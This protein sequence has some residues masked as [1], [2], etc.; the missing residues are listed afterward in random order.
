MPLD[1]AKTFFLDFEARSEVDISK[2]G[3]RAYAEHPS[4]ELLCCAFACGNEPVELWLPGEPFPVPHDCSIWAA[5]NKDTERFLLQYKLGV[6]IPPRSWVDL[7]TVA[8]AAGL[9]RNLH[10]IAEALHLPVKKQAKTA[11]LA[12]A[13]PRKLSKKNSE[14]WWS[15]KERPELYQQLYDYCR[16]DV[17]VLRAS[18]RAIP[19][20]LVMPPKEERLAVLTD[21]MNDRGV[22]V[23]LEAVALASAVVETHGR[24]LRERFQQLYPDVNPRHPPSVAKA[25]GLANARKETVRDE[26]K[27][28][29]LDDNAREALTVLKTI[30][31]ASTAKLKAFKNHACADGKVHGAMV[32]HGAGRT[33]R[34]S[35]MGVQLHNLF[36]GLHVATPDWPAIDTSD[37]AMDKFFLNLRSGL[38]DLIYPDPTRAV[39]AAMRGFIYDD[40]VGLLSG[41]FAQI[42]A[43]VLVSWARQENA[44]EAFRNKRDLYKIQAASIYNVPVE[45]VNVDQRFM[46]KTA[47]LSAG[48]QVGKF[49]FRA[50]LKE[51]FDIEIDLEES[52]R[53]VQGYRRANPK[54]KQLWYDV[55]A[56]AK[57]VLLERAERWICSTSV[58]LI[59]MRL[60]TLGPRTWLLMRLP[61]GRCLWYYE[62]ELMQGENGLRIVYWGRDIKRGGMW[63]RV[64]TYGGKLVENGTQAMAREVLAD[65]MLRLDLAGFPLTMQ[66]HDSVTAPAP[67]ERL[68]EFESLMRLEPK[69]FP[70]LPIDVDVYHG[71]RYEG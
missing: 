9:P 42:E 67:A 59:A 64:D 1:L 18:L 65:A 21:A 45:N 30:K 71:T 50:N 58:P 15:K 69:W 38:F 24:E 16:T 55:D 34:W 19:Y 12:L 56:L 48:Y 3:A 10:D 13:K 25:F 32:F 53:I 44:V 52:D 17:E 26:L 7:A 47:V 31:T 22:K 37:D 35:S 6:I 11:L 68:D 43:R 39:A 49:G 61:T 5:Q 23:D 20:E 60:L 4:T 51:K 70:G 41:D 40:E 29:D 8:S 2:V 14:K 36:R 62:P 54:V 27:F 33:G 28:L 66:V 46:G 63:A 57:K